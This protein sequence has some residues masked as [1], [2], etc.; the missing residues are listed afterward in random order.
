MPRQ[1]RRREE[2][3]MTDRQ[4]R[5]RSLTSSSADTVITHVRLLGVSHCMEKENL[6][7][8]DEK[9]H[10]DGSGAGIQV[11]IAATAL[12]ATHAADGLGAENVAAEET[13]CGIGQF[14]ASCRTFLA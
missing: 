4:L 1:I 9:E 5:R 6:A 12:L 10:A 3:P 11:L 7:F 8:P 2:T 14:F 13:E